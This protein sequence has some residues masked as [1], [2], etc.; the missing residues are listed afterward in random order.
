M[1]ESC[2]RKQNPS[3][4]ERRKIYENIHILLFKRDLTQTSKKA[5]GKKGVKCFLPI[6]YPPLLRLVP[7]Q[8]LFVTMN[9]RKPLE[10][11]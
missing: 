8:S 9:N 7:I 6:L 2:Q 3:S 4:V 1:K 10:F 5:S 11:F